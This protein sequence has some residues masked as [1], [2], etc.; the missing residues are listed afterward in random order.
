MKRNIRGFTFNFV[1]LANVGAFTKNHILHFSHSSDV[2]IN[3][4]IEP[5]YAFDIEFLLKKRRHSSSPQ[6]MADL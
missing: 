5:D 2:L 6:K 4:K 1:H 3:E